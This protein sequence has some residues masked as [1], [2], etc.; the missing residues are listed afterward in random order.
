[1]SMTRRTTP[2]KPKKEVVV[3]EPETVLCDGA[4]AIEVKWEPALGLCVECN[5][6]AAHNNVDKLCYNCHKAKE[7]FEFD[8]DRKLFIKPKGGK[9]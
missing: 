6:F 8:E 2:S 3:E 4:K 9:R 7:G 1:L 5:F